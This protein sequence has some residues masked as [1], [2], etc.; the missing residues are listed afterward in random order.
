[1]KRLLPLRS[2]PLALALA[3]S[4]C[5]RGSAETLP[6]LEAD[7]LGGTHVVLPR[8]ADGKSLVLL[9][10]FTK[11]SE[12]EL[13]AWSRKLLDNR[14]IANAAV[15]VI[16]V[17]DKTVF[18]ARKGVRKT[19]EEATVG[20]KEQRD[21]NVLITFNGDGWRQLVPP[22]DK[23]T[24]GIVVCNPSGSIVLAKREPFD[25]ANVSAVEKAATS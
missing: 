1:M 20:S 24:I 21:N 25:E 6:Q 15:Y 10:A 14:T 5:G 9:L 18:F 12:G 7:S 19:V 3:I 16:V 4:L 2:A 23:K 8:D 17:A 13:K 22:G 11:E